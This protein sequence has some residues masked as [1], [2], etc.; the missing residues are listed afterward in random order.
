MRCEVI[1]AQF[2]PPHSIGLQPDFPN[3]QSSLGHA[4]SPN[5]VDWMY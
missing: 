4:V 2:V 3:V 5:A 1:R